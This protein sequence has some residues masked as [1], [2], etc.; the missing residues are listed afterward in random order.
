VRL[1]LGVEGASFLLKSFLGLPRGRVLTTCSELPL[2]E[3]RLGL[4]FSLCVS[5][6]VVRCTCGRSDRRSECVGAPNSDNNNGIGLAA[7]TSIPDPI[8]TVSLRRL[9]V[10]GVLSCDE[11]WTEGSPQKESGSTKLRVGS[12]KHELGS[13]KYEVG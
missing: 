2:E 6:L 4:D 1:S 12:M 8:S 13:T 11:L 9:D 5:A 7:G 10:V 3:R